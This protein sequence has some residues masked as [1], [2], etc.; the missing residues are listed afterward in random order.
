MRLV[1]VGTGTV[2]PDPDRASACYWVEHDDTRVVIDCGAGALQG[3]ARARLPW[4]EL[5]HIVV[6]HFHADH[7]AEIPSLIFALRHALLVPRQTPLHIWGPAG[8]VRLFTAWA[9]ALGAWLVEPGFAVELHEVGPGA[10][11]RIGALSARFASTPHTEESLA[12]RLEAAGRSLGYTGDTGPSDALAELFHDVDL[13]V[14]E[15]S[16]PDAMAIDTHLAPRS[17]ARL[18]S[19]ARARRLAVTHV[20]PLLR[21]DEV[22]GQI[23]AAG[24]AGEILT[25]RDG[26]D[27][28]V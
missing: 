14:A 1:T 6:S 27:L 5:G 20:Y 9:A 19:L 18:A 10:P 7:I 21:L 4:G 24:Y 3:L 26:M 2:V 8:T 28:Q 13:L 11:A 25:A 17:L 12:M 23:R 15:C 22:P 16:L